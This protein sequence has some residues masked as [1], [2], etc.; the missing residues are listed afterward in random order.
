MLQKQKQFKLSPY[1]ALYDIVIPKD[2]QLRKIKEIVDF[3]FVYEELESKYCL[4]NGRNAISPIEMFKYL[5]LKSLN[6]LSDIDLVE[7]SRT[8]M[9]Y[10]FFLDKNPEDDVI[11]PSSLTKFRRQRLKDNDLL[12]ILIS[13]TVEI[14]IEKGIIKSNS[15]IVDA[16]HTLSKYNLKSPVEALKELSKKLR[17]SVYGID[18]S[19]KEKFPAKIISGTLEEELEY[20]QNLIDIIKE[21]QLIAEYPSVKSNIN[22]L[23]EVIEDDIEILKLSNDE[24]AKLGHKTAD[25][26]FFGYKSHIAMTEE[27]IITAATITSGEKHDGKELQTLV[28]KS[29]E[30]GI[31]VE[32]VI[33]DGAYSEKANIEYCKEK[34]INLIS[35]LSKTV[36]HGN[37]RT[38]GNFE[39][40]KDAGMYVCKAGHLSIRKTITGKKKRLKD[41]SSAVESYFFDVEKCKKC[42]LKEGCYREGSKTKSY[43]VTLKSHTH[44]EHEEFQKTEYFKEKS[45]ERYKIEAK[46]AELKNSHGYAKAVYSG[47]FG[48]ELQCAITLFTANIKRIMELI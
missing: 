34:E 5:L 6:P 35:K 48:M 30:A 36:T 44:Q 39:F 4:D 20:S 42:S 47:L 17:K 37:E 8:D 32:A 28:E 12:S 19:M 46:N 26:G 41:G 33:G 10:K 21:N 3:S 9:A 16:T 31:N 14:A 11:N 7:R 27:R 25:S 43:S 38:S 22:F 23:Q 13:K 2:H 24:E 29:E 45:K 40:N 18:E 1:A 15:I